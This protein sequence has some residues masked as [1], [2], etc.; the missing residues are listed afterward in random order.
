MPCR[1][2]SQRV[3][4]NTSKRILCRLFLLLHVFYARLFRLGESKHFSRQDISCHHPHLG[5]AGFDLCVFHFGLVGG[6]LGD[7]VRYGC[8]ILIR[9]SADLKKAGAP[10]RGGVRPETM[11]NPKKTLGGPSR[12][13][14]AHP[15]P[16]FGEV[17]FTNSSK[18]ES[19]LSFWTQ[20]DRSIRLTQPPNPVEKPQNRRPI[21]KGYAIRH[22]YQLQ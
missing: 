16:R 2:S 9:S 12:T 17:G 20:K 19:R 10:L 11:G 7:V 3:P 4:R 14:A 18:M 1:I 13:E 5:C 6:D 8:P 22:R 21:H 15:Q